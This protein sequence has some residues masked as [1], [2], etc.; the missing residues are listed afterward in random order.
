MNTAGGGLLPCFLPLC[1]CV[2]TYVCSPA[3]NRD[4]Q[5]RIK[6]QVYY[7]FCPAC[8]NSV[9]GG[10]AVRGQSEGCEHVGQVRTSLCLH[11]RWCCDC[12]DLNVTP[13][14]INRSSLNFHLYLICLIQKKER[15]QK[16]KQ[17]ETLKPELVC[18]FPLALVH[19]DILCFQETFISLNFS[20]ETMVMSH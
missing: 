12:V 5:T 11:H 10:C 9:L 13:A 1:V 19:A 16:T 17:I 2:F 4:R 7:A 3:C 14:P 15:R 8:S 20:P 6:L 18:S